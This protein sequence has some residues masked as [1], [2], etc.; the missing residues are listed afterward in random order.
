MGRDTLTPDKTTLRRYVSQKLTQQQMV[1]AWERESNIRVARSAIGMALARHGL[2]SS[3]TRAR[4]DELLPWRVKAEHTDAY[5]A[6]MLRLE[7]RKRRKGR[8]LPEQRQRL[9]AWLARL[10]ET[11]SVVHYDPLTPEGFWWVFRE[12]VDTD[13]IRHPD[14]HP[15][16]K[17]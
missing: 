7:A 17:R 6:Q 2:R 13:I 16:D 8:L 14:N 15:Q 10:E 4:Y 12:P 5:D 3:T 11:G 9:S 1:E